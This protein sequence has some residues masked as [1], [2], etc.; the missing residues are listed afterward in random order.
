MLITFLVVTSLL[1]GVLMLAPVEARALLYLPRNNAPGSYNALLS[2]INAH[3]LDDPYPVQYFR[4]LGNLLRGDWGWSPAMK[5]D[6][7]QALIRRVPVTA[8]LTLYSLLVF[9]PLGLVNG[10]LAGAKRGRREDQGFRLLAF[11]ATSIP[12]FI[13]GLMLLAIFYVGLRWFPVGRLSVSKALVVRSESFRLYTGM[14]TFD[15][16]LNGRLDVTWDAFRHLILPV[17][18][19]SLTHWATLGR[20]TRATFIEELD[21]EYVLAARA[22]GIKD[23]RIIWKHAFRNALPPALSSVGLSAAALITGVFVVEI[24]FSLPGVSEPLNTSSYV[25]GQF[26]P[27]IPATMGFAVFGVLLVLPLMLLLD[28]L[29]AILHP[30]IRKETLA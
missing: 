29:Q 6:V 11:L 28:L 4:W 2:A 14:L 20:V 18:T 8:E 21:K 27:D 26:V 17:F 10:V 13:L 15:G 9:I 5:D 24:I 16:L 19:L 7:L 22:R 12:P 23:H 25:A 1:Y 30:R 3:G